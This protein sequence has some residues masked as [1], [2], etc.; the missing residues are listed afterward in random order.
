MVDCMEHCSRYMGNGEGCFGMVW[1]ESNSHCW[2]RNSSTGTVNLAKKEGHFS[3]LVVDGQMKGY[4]TKCPGDDASI[5]SLPGVDGL[6]YTLN[7]NKVVSGFDLCSSGY[8]KPCLESPYQGFFHTKSLEECLTICVDQRPL[9]KAVSWS[10]D[11]KIGFANCFLKSGFP[12]SGLTAPGPKNGVLHSATIT[13]I[14]PINRDCPANKTYTATTAKK[15]FDIHCGQ[16]NTGTNFTSVH[17]QNITSCMDTCAN[18]KD[19]CIGVVFESDLNGGYKNCRLQ[20]STSVMSDSATATY[21]ALSSS[22][23]TEPSTPSSS[24]SS[25]AWIAGPVI[26][27]IALLALLI[28]LA[29]WWRKRKTSRASSLPVEK[30]GHEFTQYGAAPAYSPGGATQAYSPGATTAYSPAATH[31]QYYDTSPIQSHGSAAPLE[32]SGGSHE[33]SELP[34]VSDKYRYEGKG[35]AQELPS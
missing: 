3:A 10:P 27:G 34:A 9:C 4:D 18:S 19:N 28:V 11:L 33:A 16:V 12:E 25:K 6:Q 21:A 30:D 13:R 1:I 8:P 31:M 2:L 17:S 26:G 32:L 5:R 35:G 15:Q 14:D 23:S 20:N 7:C 22:L 29:L 24:S